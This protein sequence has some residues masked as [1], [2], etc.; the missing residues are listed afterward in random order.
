MAWV[1]NPFTGKLDYNTDSQEE[2]FPSTIIT[3]DGGGACST[4]G[5]TLGRPFVAGGHA[6]SIYPPGA[7]LNGGNAV[8]IYVGN[9][10]SGG[11]A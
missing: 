6:V 4:Y 3:L 7:L 5:A 1:F 10:L 11:D 2:V 9:A 8:S